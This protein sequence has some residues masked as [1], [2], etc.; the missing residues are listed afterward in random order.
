[1][2]HGSVAFVD[3]DRYLFTAYRSIELNPV[4]AAMVEHAE[5]HGSSV[6]ANLVLCEDP[7][8]TPHPWFIAMGDMPLMRAEG[9]GA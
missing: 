4:R 1:M 8:V 7:L 5:H 3:S 2:Q 6:H 9:Y